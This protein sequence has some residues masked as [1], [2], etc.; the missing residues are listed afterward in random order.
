MDRNTFRRGESAVANATDNDVLPAAPQKNLFIGDNGLVCA[1]V[2]AASSRQSRNRIEDWQALVRYPKRSES[3]A[4]A[5]VESNASVRSVALPLMAMLSNPLDKRRP[6]R[7][8]TGELA[9][10]KVIRLRGSKLGGTVARS[11]GRSGQT[12]RPLLKA[13]RFGQELS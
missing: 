2:R 7:I 12:C 5:L 1:N 13:R 4:A 3:T 10:G 8:V 6:Q 9:A 11:P